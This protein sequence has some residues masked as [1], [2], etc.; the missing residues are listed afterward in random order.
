MPNQMVKGI[1]LRH[2][3]SKVQNKIITI[4]VFDSLFLLLQKIFRLTSV[5]KL[6]NEV[7]NMNSEI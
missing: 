3:W 2:V 4:A 7:S 5:L 1:V 6:K